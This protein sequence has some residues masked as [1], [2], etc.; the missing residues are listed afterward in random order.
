MLGEPLDEV[1]HEAEVRE[2]TIRAIARETSGSSRFASCVSACAAFAGRRG[3]NSL[4]TDD[5][6]EGN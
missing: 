6:P 1:C 2:R 4:G 3:G 5:L